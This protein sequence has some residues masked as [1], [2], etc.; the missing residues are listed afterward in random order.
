MPDKDVVPAAFVV[1]F[2]IPAKVGPIVVVPLKF[3][4]KSWFAPVT[5]KENVGVL[6]ERVASV[7]RVTASLY[8]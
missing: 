1:R 5:P 2:L 7:P 4:V 6:P 8:N 3:R